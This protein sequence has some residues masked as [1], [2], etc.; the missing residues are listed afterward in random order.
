MNEFLVRQVTTEW[1][2]EWI[3]GFNLCPFAAKPHREKKIRVKVFSGEDLVALKG[4]LLEECKRLIATTSDELETTLVVCPMVLPDFLDYWDYVSYFEDEMELAGYEGILQMASFHPEYYFGDSDPEDTANFTNRSPF[5]VF[6]FLR[7]AS[8][9]AAVDSHPDIESV[10]E[11]NIQFMSGKS[12]DL[13]QLQLKT[14]QR[15]A[16][17]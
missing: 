11:R 13:L 10:P 5:P 6:H 12:Y 16:N 7:E 8:V 1:L 14:W 2:E 15:R 17:Q 3:L 9:S 4:F